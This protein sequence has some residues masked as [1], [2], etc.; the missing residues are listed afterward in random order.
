MHELRFAFALTAFG[1]LL[2]LVGWRNI[3]AVDA[4]V[5]PA[6]AAMSPEQRARWRRTSVLLLAGGLVCLAAGAVLALVVLIVRH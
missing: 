2:P 6:F 5:E 1:L 4:A 3:R